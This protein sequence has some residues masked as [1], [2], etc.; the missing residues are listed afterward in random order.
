MSALDEVITLTEAAAGFP[1]S[2]AALAKAAQRGR[3]AHR[4][5]DDGGILT[6]KS[7]VARYVSEAEAWRDNG[8]GPRNRQP[9]RRPRRR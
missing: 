9:K 5:T 6:T 7:D 8:R 3:L 1:V 4:R 2:R